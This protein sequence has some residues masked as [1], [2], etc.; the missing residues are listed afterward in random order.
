MYALHYPTSLG[1]VS[2]EALK[3]QRQPSILL[4]IVV[5]REAHTVTDNLPLWE[6]G[7]TEF[8]ERLLLDKTL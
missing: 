8:T 6:G 3:L 1:S 5:S 2:L 7:D 4:L